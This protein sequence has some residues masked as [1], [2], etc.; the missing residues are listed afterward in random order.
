MQQK[1]VTETPAEDRGDDPKDLDQ[2]LG[3]RDFFL[4]P[5]LGHLYRAQRKS[6]GEDTDVTYKVVAAFSPKELLGGVDAE[7]ERR[8]ADYADRIAAFEKAWRFEECV[9]TVQIGSEKAR[10]RAAARSSIDKQKIEQQLSNAKDQPGAE[11]VAAR[12]TAGLRRLRERCGYREWPPSNEA[13]EREWRRESLNVGERVWRALSDSEKELLTDS[14]TNELKC[15]AIIDHHFA[16][17]TG[18]FEGLKVCPQCGLWLH[19]RDKR[20]IL[21]AACREARQE[22]RRLKKKGEANAARTE[23]TLSKM[24]GERQRHREQCCYNNP[25][26][27]ARE[28]DEEL[29]AEKASI[30]TSVADLEA[31][32]EQDYRRRSGRVK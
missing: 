9:G 14:G 24:R 16:E 13:E 11:L 18:L 7:I 10:R 6:T 29:A 19:P 27:D 28:L 21:H 15:D 12:M 25:C 17:V 1:S 4:L 32:Q 31:A 26:L 5:K 2:A 22:A 20:Q 3:L 23:E 8:K 30:V